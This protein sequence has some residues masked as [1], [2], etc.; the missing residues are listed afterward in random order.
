MSFK[1]AGLSRVWQCSTSPCRIRGK[2]LGGFHNIHHDCFMVVVLMTIAKDINI[3][4]FTPGN[5]LWLVT[6]ILSGERAADLKVFGVSPKLLIPQSVLLPPLPLPG[7][8]ATIAK[9]KL[10][11]SKAPQLFSLYQDPPVPPTNQ[12]SHIHNPT[13][14][15]FPKS[16]RHHPMTPPNPYWFS[17]PPKAMCHILPPVHVI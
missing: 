15:T 3:L 10:N 16:G 2:L 8:P 5:Q 17:S 12:S 11:S 6:I 9:T 1:M 13:I 4:S 14:T 7:N